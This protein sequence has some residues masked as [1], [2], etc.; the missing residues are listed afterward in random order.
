MQNQNSVW[1]KNALSIKISFIG[2]LILLLLI[3][4]AMITGLIEERQAKSHEAQREILDTWGANQ[5]LSGPVITV[6]FQGRKH[7]G[8]LKLKNDYYHFLP[9]SLNI[10][11][12][13]NAKVLNRGIFKVPVY[14]TNLTF[15]GTIQKPR[16]PDEPHGQIMYWDKAF[17]T[18]GISDLRAIRNAIRMDCQEQKLVFGPAATPVSFF[19]NQVQTTMSL[20]NDWQE[21]KILDFQITLAVGGGQRLHFLPLGKETTVELTSSWN[22]PGFNGAWLPKTRTVDETGFNAQWFVSHLGRNHPQSWIDGNVDKF[23]MNQNSFGVDILLP[24]D[25]YKKSYRSARYAILFIALT[26]TVFFLFEVVLGLRIH[27]LQY[28]M[29]GI[30]LCIFYL[31]LLS[32]SEHVP[33]VMAYLAASMGVTAII[34]IYSAGVLKRMRRA[35]YMACMFCGVYGFLYVLLQLTEMALLLGSVGVF[36]ILGFIMVF[37][38]NMDWYALPG[39]GSEGQIET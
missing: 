29:V 10:V 7:D 15:S 21:D 3:P 38:R 5:V 35:I 12:D 34:T 31:L 4:M 11:G 16:G 8:E 30:A 1:E 25:I 20:G 13:V 23:A 24:I 37:T 6:P 19:D 32:L 9:Q 39:K 14:D 2:L 28:L 36:L 22:N 18:M 17:V 33:F 26:F 27:P